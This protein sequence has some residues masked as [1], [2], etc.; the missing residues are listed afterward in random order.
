VDYGK[1]YNKNYYQSY[2]TGDKVESY[3]DAEDLKQFMDNVADAIVN[4][5]HPKTVLDVGC[6]MGYLVAA[7]RD[8]GVQAYGIDVS[9]YAISKVRKDIQPYCRACSALDP[10]PDDFP[11]RYDL[12]TNIEVAEHLYEED[13]KKLINNLCTYSDQILFSSTS[14]DFMEK[15]HLNVQQPEYWAKLFACNGFIKHLD[16]HSDFISQNAYLFTK[17][18]SST[19]KIIEDYERY[20]R[21]LKLSKKKIAGKLYYSTGDP[22]DEGKIISVHSSLNTQNNFEI[23]L[24]NNTVSARFDPMETPCILKNL[25][26]V[27]LNSNAQIEVSHDGVIID[28]YVIFPKN[29]PQIQI[30]F[31]GHK[32]HLL[33]ITF[34]ILPWTDP[35]FYPLIKTMAQFPDSTA[36]L[37]QQKS[38]NSL[39]EEAKKQQSL[40]KALQ[41][42]IVQQQSLYDSAINA[43]EKER[44]AQFKEFQSVLL[45]KDI[46]FR[47]LYSKFR[48]LTNTSQQKISELQNEIVLLQ[49]QQADKD[50]QIQNVMGM[51]HVIS[52]STCWRITKPIRFM[53]D[54]VKQFMKMHRG[55]AQFYK[56]LVYLRHYGFRTTF[57]KTKWYLKNKRNLKSRGTYNAL[58]KLD[59]AELEKQKNTIFSKK[60]KFSIVVPLYNTPESFLT[61]MIESV[62]AQTYCNWELCLADGSDAEH[63]SVQKIC[64]RFS[65]KDNRILYKKLEK[66]KGISENTNECIR[67]SSGDYI[68]LL[69]HDDI[70]HPS[71]LFEVMKAICEKNADFIYTDEATF[72]KN[73]DNIITTHFKPD[74]AIDNLRANNYIC[75]F[76]VFKKDLLKEVGLFR[77]EYDGSQDHD[78][79]LRLTHIAKKI[80]HIPKVL[81]YWRS[82]ENSV[83]SDI[84]SKTYAIEAGKKAVAQ[85]ILRCGQ[86]AKVE[87]SKAFPTIYRIKYELEETPLVSILIPNK[88]SIDLLQACIDSITSKTTYPNYEIIIIDNQSSDVSI[89]NYYKKIQHCANLKILSWDYPFNYSAINNFGAKHAQGKYLLL[90]NNDTKV[91]TPDWIEQMLMYVQ[92]PDVGAAG[93]KLY[94]ENDTIQHAGIILGLGKD[95]VAGHMFD[96]CAKSNLG[97]M[98]RL[99]Y[100]QDVSAVTGACMMVKRFLYDSL[101]GLDENLAVAFNDVDFCMRIRKL[102][103]LIVFTPYS[104]LY[105]LCSKTRGLEDNPQKQ[106]RFQ[107]EAAYFKFRWKKELEAG[108]PYYNPNFSLD[109]ND[110]SIN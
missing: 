92:R 72:N 39:M 83:A 29:D 96:G 54:H 77:K 75:H 27:A 14:S 12:V 18:N 67:M 10:L 43:K 24:P 74:F 60:I 46:R 89:K 16:Y 4:T 61:E 99:C 108:D 97:Y 19:E 41:E 36:A 78:M 51:Y 103:Y 84:N 69:D 56:G 23:S 107:K 42:R 47:K 85:H 106:A 68:G 32:V 26:I 5:L 13:G 81:Y 31:H 102:G 44:I 52:T 86:R 70:L 30:D 9:P 95:R 17:N 63:I 79:V 82:H 38:Y 101:G 8:R 94:Y 58:N 80:V 28:N 2:S 7:L 90:L 6:A 91:I 40:I 15:T 21:Q 88:N 66:N 35:A 33:R 37:Q 71:A 100:A 93:A 57:Q 64:T 45:Q 104:E 62:R 109:K 73:L 22:F 59:K 25:S 53:L 48:Q 65:Q 20:I 105:H 110:F 87:S 98:G 49:K 55:S 34:E 50:E 76:T 1:I 3:E 11:Q